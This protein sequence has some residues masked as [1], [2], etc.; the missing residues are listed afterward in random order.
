[1]PTKWRWAAAACGIAAH[2]WCAAGDALP[3]EGTRNETAGEL[4]CRLAPSDTAVT[5]LVHARFS[6]V[7]DD[8]HAGVETSVDGQPVACEPGARQQLHGETQGDTLQCRFT[9]PRVPAPGGAVRVRVDWHHASP[10][11]VAITRE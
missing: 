7:H 11:R 4:T 6:G 2:A 9:L 3:C 10:E 5:V 1:M 8:S